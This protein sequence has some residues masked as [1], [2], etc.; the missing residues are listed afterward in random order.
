MI[1][2]ATAQAEEESAKRS[3]PERR[4]IHPEKSTAP[5]ATPKEQIEYQN[6]INARLEKEHREAMIA[7]LTAEVAQGG[8]LETKATRKPRRNG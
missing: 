4:V 3:K 6:A 1:D 8:T 7:K 2:A 5:T